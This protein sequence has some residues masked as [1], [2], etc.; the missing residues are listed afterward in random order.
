MLDLDWTKEITRFEVI[1]HTSGD[2]RGRCYSKGWPLDKIKI[3]LSVQDGG[4]T[5]KVFVDDGPREG[6]ETENS[7]KP[8]QP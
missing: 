7:G 5:L 8:G 4:R 2:F 3:E 1:D 6:S